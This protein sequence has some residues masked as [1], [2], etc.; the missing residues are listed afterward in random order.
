M[1]GLLLQDWVTI[2]S[3]GDLSAWVTQGADRWIDLEDYEDLVFY[4]DV[5][6]VSG[7]AVQM[8]Y[9]TSPT[10]LETSFLTMMP[11]FTLAAGVRVDRA[12]FATAAVPAARYVRWKLTGPVG[13]WDATFRIWLATFAMA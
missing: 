10:K 11:A 5:R 3:N 6:E 2:R 9:Q 13:T 12:F 8:S 1:E 4:L 7:G